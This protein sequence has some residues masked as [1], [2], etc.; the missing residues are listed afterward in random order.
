M[1]HRGGGGR[2]D[3]LG[4]GDPYNSKA[5]I[6]RADLFSV[7]APDEAFGII[8]Q[9]DLSGAQ[10]GIRRS[11][12]DSIGQCFDGVA[13]ISKVG[14]HNRWFDSSTDWWGGHVSRQE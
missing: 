2:R 5:T 13:R 7:G 6:V 3:Y 11:K 8:E 12:Y 4:T 10:I 1:F 9:W 14:K